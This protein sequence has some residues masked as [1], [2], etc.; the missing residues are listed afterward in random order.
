MLALHLD[1]LSTYGLM[2]ERSLADIKLLIQRF[3]ATDYLA[4]TESKYCPDPAA[5]RLRRPARSS[6]SPAGRS[7]GGH[8]A[9]RGTGALRVLARLRKEIALRD[10]IPPY[11]VFSDA[12]LKDMCVVLPKSREEMLLVKGVGDHKLQ[13]YGEAFLACIAEHRPKD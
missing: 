9:G 12:T 10:H 13:K 4:L 8:E 3:V 2:K 6:E 5:L 7:K 11:V 1:T